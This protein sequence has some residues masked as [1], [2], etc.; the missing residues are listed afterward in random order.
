MTT[1]ATTPTN[2]I[3]MNFNIVNSGSNP[4]PLSSLKFRYYFTRDTAKALTFNCDYARVKCSNII[5]R[6]VTLSQPVAGADRYLEISIAST[7]GDLAANG[8]TGEIL[9]RFNKSD[10]S[11]FNQ[12]NDYSF[13]PTKRAFTDWDHI[14]L[15]QNGT[16]IWGTPPAGAN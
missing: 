5:G 1:N 10:W 9:V 16:R 13:D 7:A 2:Q 15:Y 8:Q 4:V 3:A 11:N 12:S 6:F 14:T